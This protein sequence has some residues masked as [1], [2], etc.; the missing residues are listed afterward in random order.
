MDEGPLK[1]GERV[2]EVGPTFLVRQGR[3]RPPRRGVLERIS[4]PVAEVAWDIGQDQTGAPPGALRRVVDTSWLAREV[5]HVLRHGFPLCE[6][7]REVPRDWP[8]GHVWVSYRDP[9]ARQ[10]SCGRCARQ[11]QR[12]MLRANEKR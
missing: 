10:A 8:D 4:G 5:V 2:R 1:P 12:L 11:A 6:F 3:D 9:L 7:S